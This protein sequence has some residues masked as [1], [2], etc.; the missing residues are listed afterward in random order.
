MPTTEA[1]LAET[2]WLTKLAKDLVGDP[3][4]AEDVV[5]DTLLA[6]L[7]ERQRPIRSLRPWLQ[8]VARNFAFRNRQ[9]DKQRTHVERKSRAGQG[10]ALPSAAEAVERASVHR[11]VVDAVL[12]L[13]EPYRSTIV[14][15]Y[16]EDLPLASGLAKT[17]KKIAFFF[18]TCAI[19]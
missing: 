6:A 9:R 2:R 18:A 13:A 10:D 5:Q 7:G 14:L 12:G 3:H 4:A 11:S 17:W 19:Q 16:L 8:A 1:L 15:R